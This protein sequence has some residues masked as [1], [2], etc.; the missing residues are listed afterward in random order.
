MIIFIHILSN[1]YFKSLKGDVAISTI[2]TIKTVIAP[3]KGIIFN[4]IRI[5]AAK[6]NT[7]PKV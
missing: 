2:P 5:T 4:I 7:I 6:A 3:G 1:C